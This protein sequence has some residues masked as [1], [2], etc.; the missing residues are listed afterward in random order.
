MTS[1]HS[2][3]KST[4]E[5]WKRDVLRTFIQVV[6]LKMDTFFPKRK[7]GLINTVPVNTEVRTNLVACLALTEDISPRV[8]SGWNI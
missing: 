4:G 3:P 2:I 7:G 6:P 8:Y 1:F 5:R